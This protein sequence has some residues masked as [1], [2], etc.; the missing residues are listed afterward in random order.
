ML[1][2]AIH[3][4]SPDIQH[5]LMKNFSILKEIFL[6]TS[7]PFMDIRKYPKADLSKRGSARFWLA[8]ATGNDCSAMIVWCHVIRWMTNQGLITSWACTPH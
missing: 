2:V 8:A 5:V 6:K 1:Y 7:F 4:K 3:V